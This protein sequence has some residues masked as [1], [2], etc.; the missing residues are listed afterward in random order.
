LKASVKEV[1][2][3]PILEHRDLPVSFNPF[4]F[5]EVGKS[6]IFDP[7]YGDLK[8]FPLQFGRTHSERPVSEDRFSVESVG[9]ELRPGGLNVDRRHLEHQIDVVDDVRKSPVRLPNR[10]DNRVP[11]KAVEMHRMVSRVVRRKA[12][13]GSLEGQSQFAL[14]APVN[15][16]ENGLTVS[17]SKKRAYFQTHDMTIHLTS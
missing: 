9:L 2:R 4:F 11:A 16:G 3:F 15:L 1:A 5:V 7:V 12:V 6:W 10:F 8:Q 17:T 13:K 14:K